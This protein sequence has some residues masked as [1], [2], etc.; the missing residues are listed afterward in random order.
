MKNSHYPT[1]LSTQEY[2][3]ASALNVSYRLGF[4]MKDEQLYN[5]WYE[6]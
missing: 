1:L 4:A 6:L 2:L 3:V 5:E